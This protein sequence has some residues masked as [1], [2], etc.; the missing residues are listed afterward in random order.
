[1]IINS[2]GKLVSPSDD[3]QRHIVNVTMK[4]VHWG[5]KREIIDFEESL[6]EARWGVNKMNPIRDNMLEVII[7]VTKRTLR[8][9][10]RERI[11]P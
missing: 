3:C 4:K 5:L 7:N 6:T 11:I 2:I 1:M 10:S 9:F 8:G